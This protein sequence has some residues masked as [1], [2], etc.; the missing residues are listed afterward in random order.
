MMLSIIVKATAIMALALAGVAVARRSRASV[1]HLI[2]AAGFMILLILPFGIW[3][4]PPIQLEVPRLPKALPLGILEPSGPSTP[5]TVEVETAPVSSRS[6][7]PLATILAAAWAAGGILFSLPIAAGLWQLRRLRR[8]GVPWLRGRG[9]LA[10]NVDVLMHDAING[11]AT[12]GIARP[13]VVFPREAENWND[14]ELQRALIHEGEHVRRRDCVTHVVARLVCAMYWFHPLVWMSW[15]RLGLEA[16][17]A[18]DDAVLR[19]SEAA[20]Y[21]DQLVTIAKQMTSAA[22]TPLLA[23]ASRSDLRLRVSALLDSTQPRGRA[24]AVCISVA[25]AAALLLAGIVSPLRAAQ[26]F[27]VASIKKNTSGRGP[28]NIGG[29]LQPNGR[30]DV[31]NSPLDTLISIAYGLDF[32]QLD[33][34]GHK[35]VSQAFDVDAR[36]PENSVPQGLE[37]RT[38]MFRTMMQ[39]LLKDRFKLAVHKETIDTPIYILVPAKNG[40]RLKATVPDPNCA[41]PGACRYGGGPAS[42]Y[43]GRGMQLDDLA[44]VLTAFLDRPVLNRT[45][46]TGRFDID[47]PPWS[48]S[49]L[50]RPGGGELDGTEPA[51]DPLNPS[52]YQVLQDQLGLKL[53]ATR[54]PH[55]M[56][57][58]DHVEPPTE[59]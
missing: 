6:V 23:M 41:Q 27:E 38:A 16:E 3:L 50:Q 1:R 19:H 57:I 37:E 9:V 44:N 30:F 18:C 21:A 10:G 12:F 56:Y 34:N 33:D 7:I 14:L 22:R 58:V 2:L 4:A 24:G 28:Y 13:V 26:E 29:G 45:G 48:R 55:D 49:P 51:P 36:A 47:L 40:P 42:G 43:K 31:T 8:I 15:R 32:K 53:E 17:R 5:M 46:I 39:K 52:I 20:E 35:L 59:N 11:P 54:G 25:L